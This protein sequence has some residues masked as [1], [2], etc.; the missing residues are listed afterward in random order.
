MENTKII[1]DLKPSTN[2]KQIRIILGHIGYYIKFVGH[3]SDI[4]FPLDELL[5]IDIEFS[6]STDCGEVF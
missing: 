6:W 2:L 3:Y 1:L 4:N 5:K